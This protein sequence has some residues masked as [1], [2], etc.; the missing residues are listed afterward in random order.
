MEEGGDSV[1]RRAVRPARSHNGLNIMTTV[2]I[3]SAGLVTILGWLVMETMKLQKQ[4]EQIVYM[5]SRKSSRPSVSMP[6]EES[7]RPVT[8][9]GSLLRSLAGNSG[10]LSV[11][12]APPPL[13]SQS[14]QEEDDEDDEDDEDGEAHEYIDKKSEDAPPSPPLE[15]VGGVLESSAAPSIAAPK[16]GRTRKKSGPTEDSVPA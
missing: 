8:T 12:N 5:I 6:P 15:E 11:V 2:C 3:M 14:I 16:V 1:C 10:I 13:A 7:R 9:A 4:V